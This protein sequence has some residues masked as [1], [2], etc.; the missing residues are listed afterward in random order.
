MLKD[1]NNVSDTYII[2]IHHIYLFINAK[3]FVLN[4]VFIGS[5]KSD[6]VIRTYIIK[7]L[8]S[9]GL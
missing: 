4:F 2:D 1:Y 8:Q 3:I 9:Y 7:N 6:S 5:K